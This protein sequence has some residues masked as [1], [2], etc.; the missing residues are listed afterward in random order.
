METSRI[1][2]VLLDNFYP[3]GLF[4]F[5]IIYYLLWIKYNFHSVTFNTND[6]ETAVSIFNYKPYISIFLNN[7]FSLEILNLFFGYCFFPSVISVLLF[8]IFK[9][10]LANNI[11]ALSLTFLSVSASENYPFHKFLFSFVSKISTKETINI[12]ENFE[13][14]GFPIPAFSIFFF[15][16]VF[17]L[18]LKSIK[19]HR[20]K[21]Y[22]ITFL[23]LVMFHIHPVDGLIGN[24]Y[25][26]GFI[27]ILS[28][29]KK[30]RIK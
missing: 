25:W 18:T 8:L 16:L 15:C 27:G 28:L 20:Q 29:Q 9:K 11:W 4:S 22:F 7:I 19:L 13:I 5:F 1:K 21:I 23:W 3:I 24:L 6:L 2:K 12:Y 30:N 26:I 17:Y 14:M 10:I